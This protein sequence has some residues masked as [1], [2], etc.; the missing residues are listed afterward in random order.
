VYLVADI[1][2]SGIEWTPIGTAVNFADGISGAP[3]KSGTPA[4]S[5][6]STYFNGTFDGQG[7]TVSNMNVTSDY[8]AG[9][10]GAVYDGTIRNLVIDDATVTSV[11]DAAII[12]SNAYSAS[13]GA[14]AGL[15]LLS[16]IEDV[17]VTGSTVGGYH[18]VGGIVGYM[19][20]T[21]VTDCTVTGSTITATPNAISR[22]YDN[23]DKVGGIVGFIIKGY[24]STAD[25]NT[26]TGNT[27]SDTSINAYRDVGGVI[28]CISNASCNVTANTVSGVTIAVDQTINGYGYKPLNIGNVI[29]RTITDVITLSG[30]QVE[31]VTMTAK[32]LVAN[33]S[34]LGSIVG[35]CKGIAVTA[36][37]RNSIT[38]DNDP[39]NIVTDVTIDLAGNTLTF[40]TA[41]SLRPFVMNDGSSLTIIG[42]DAGST[43]NYTNGG[44]IDSLAVTCPA[45]GYSIILNG[46]T[47][48]GDVDN[49]LASALIKVRST[50]GAV[51]LEM[52]DVTYVD[53]SATNYIVDLYSANSDLDIV[54]DIVGGQ[55][56][57]YFGFHTRGTATFDGVT[58]DTR[59]AAFEIMGDTV[60]TDC[61]ITVAP[62]VTVVN[63]PSGGIAVSNGGVAT[64]DGG[65]ISGNM[66]AVYYVYSSGGD[67]T[68]TDV[69]VTG[70]DYTNFVAIDY[71]GSTVTVDGTVYTQT[72]ADPAIV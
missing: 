30:N 14:V 34:D 12:T 10:F 55:Y 60:I 49:A 48:V 44:L 50:T 39:V 26:V 43:V 15:A 71:N 3:T 70:A 52:T 6:Q 38:Y 61:D 47:Y 68:A 57:G 8:C 25:S 53:Q 41:T 65:S 59:G 42:T 45:Q 11:Y 21:V 9:L 13:A 35:T 28:G 62:G 19:N 20:D 2:L 24:Y 4:G 7:H 29:G 27:V 31:N 16:M 33:D 54:M 63:A 5:F 17:T 66:D 1:D 72:T 40:T 18:F 37:L 51:N 32:V 22:G 64:V 58:I 36:V 69:D 46:G 23:G 67:I 56:T